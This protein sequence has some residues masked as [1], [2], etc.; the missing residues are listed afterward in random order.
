MLEGQCERK[1]V[2]SSPGCVLVNHTKGVY[3]HLSIKSKIKG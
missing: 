2:Q 3:S 1:W